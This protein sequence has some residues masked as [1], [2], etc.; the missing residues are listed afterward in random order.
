MQIPP[1][2]EHSFT[3]LAAWVLRGHGISAI[4][5]PSATFLQKT[6]ISVNYINTIYSIQ[7]AATANAHTVQ[8]V[9][10]TSGAAGGASVYSDVFNITVKASEREST[11]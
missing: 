3:C 7:D 1:A 4:F 8:A 5:T 2:S 6:G 10:W 11:Y 9:L